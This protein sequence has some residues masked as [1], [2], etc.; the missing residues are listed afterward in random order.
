M[1]D[2]T[3][4][5]SIKLL[6]ATNKKIAKLTI[7][8]EELT[9]SIIATIGHNYEGEKSYE[10]SEWKVTCKTPMIYSLDTKA[11]RERGVFLDDAFNPVKESIAYT[12]DKK[13]FEEYMQI[14]PESVRN[15]LCELVT[16]KPGKS[17]VTLKNRC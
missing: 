6:E 17:S 1:K 16:K 15:A 13:K 11:Y 10:F 12:V 5:D 3:L 2:N 8:K 7:Q 9:S 14:A 4:E